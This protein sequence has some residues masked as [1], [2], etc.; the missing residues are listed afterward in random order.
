MGEIIHKFSRWEKFGQKRGYLT[1]VNCIFNIL[2]L[3]NEEGNDGEMITQRRGG[4][5]GDFWGGREGKIT[6]RHRGT[7]GSRGSAS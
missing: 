2:G 3:K 1:Y 5:G 4:R 6:Q 7:E